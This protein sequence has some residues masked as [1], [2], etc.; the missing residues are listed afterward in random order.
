MITLDE[1]KQTLT[2]NQDYQ[3]LVRTGVIPEDLRWDPKVDVD[4]EYEEIDGKS[5]VTVTLSFRKH[6]GAPVSSKV[7][8]KINYPELLTEQKA[9]ADFPDDGWSAQQQ[10]RWEYEQIKEIVN[11][12]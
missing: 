8:R 4:S 2:D 12:L 3:T 10:G 7:S 6:E 9:Y 1:L 11:R 5:A